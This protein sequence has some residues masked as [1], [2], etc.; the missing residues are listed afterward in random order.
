MKKL[1]SHLITMFAFSICA[2][3]TLAYTYATHDLSL[4]KHGIL[5]NEFFW[6]DDLEGMENF[7]VTAKISFGDDLLSVDSTSQANIYI[8]E[9]GYETRRVL[10]PVETH[11]TWSQEGDLTGW[12]LRFSLEEGTF[13]PIT[14]EGHFEMILESSYGAGTCNCDR[15]VYAYDLLSGDYGRY[16]WVGRRGFWYQAESNLANW[17]DAPVSMPNAKVSE[18]TPH[19]LLLLGVVLIGATRLRSIKDSQRVPYKP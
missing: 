12:N 9:W 15:Y 14:G 6:S 11:F 7:L 18:P 17:I 13:S 8:E 10:Q 1:A 5:S 2:P 16:R 19:Y 4:T 3:F